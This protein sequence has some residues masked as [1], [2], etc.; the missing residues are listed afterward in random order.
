MLEQ[1][2]RRTKRELQSN[3]ELIEVA[4]SKKYKISCT[5]V[6]ELSIHDLVYLKENKANKQIR[7]FVVSILDSFLPFSLLCQLNLSR[8]SRACK[9]RKTFRQM[10]SDCKKY[11]RNLQ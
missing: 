9:K 11:D 4:V 7:Y 3:V 8:F 10:Y 5:V 1:K 6:I 2:N